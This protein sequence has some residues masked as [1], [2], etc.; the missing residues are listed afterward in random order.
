MKIK[1]ILFDLDGT[2]IDSIPFHRQ[3]FRK[4]F[5]KFGK[6]LPEKAV[7]DYI[8]WSTEEIYHH[9]RIK[10]KLG[11]NLE[12]FLEIRRDIYYSLIKKKNLVFKD[13]VVLLEKLKKNFKLALVSNSS[14]LTVQFSTPKKVL[15]RF[16]RI[17][18]FSDVAKGKPAPD[19]L[20]L[21]AKKLRVPPEQCLV[22]GDSVVD[23]LASRAAGMVVVILFGKTGGSSLPE[24][25]AK[26]PDAVVFSA[27]EL[28]LLLQF[29][30]QNS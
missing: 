19:M 3:S 5:R 13:R 25:R 6:S 21:A 16:D 15:S 18:S 14:H 9:L 12:S 24:I 23:I 26:K 2:L 17:V 4:L 28:E 7:H 10:E 27:K 22:V 30:G 8:R 29:W 1:A 11:L 20:L